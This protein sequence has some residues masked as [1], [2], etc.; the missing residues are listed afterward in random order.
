MKTAFLNFLKSMYSDGKVTEKELLDTQNTSLIRA[1]TD[2]KIIEDP[3]I[4]GYYQILQEISYRCSG[5]CPYCMNK[6]LDYSETEAPVEDYIAFYDKIIAQGGT[7]R[8]QITGGEPLQP[9]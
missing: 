4:H 6:G 5:Q 7:I 8:L 9:E 3:F 2:G 1:V